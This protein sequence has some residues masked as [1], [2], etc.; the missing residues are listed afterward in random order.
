VVPPLPGKH[1]LGGFNARRQATIAEARADV[2]TSSASVRA[3]NILKEIDLVLNLSIG[4]EQSELPT[5]D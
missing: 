1:R 4:D 2:K 3:Q 5:H